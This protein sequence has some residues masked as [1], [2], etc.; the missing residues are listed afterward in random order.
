MRAR[1]ATA[2]FILMICENYDN[3]EGDSRLDV[4]M[5]DERYFCL[6]QIMKSSYKTS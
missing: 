4:R 6:T 1:K 5:H 2:V 3:Y